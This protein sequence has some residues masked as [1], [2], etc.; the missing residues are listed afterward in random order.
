[1]IA[2]P[3]RDSAWVRS[4]HSVPFA[5]VSAFSASLRPLR[6][7]LARLNTLNEGYTAL[8]QVSV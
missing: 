5:V 4:E 1:M 2:G 7:T 8:L 3:P 6:F